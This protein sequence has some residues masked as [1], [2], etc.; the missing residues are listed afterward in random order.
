MRILVSINWLLG[1][2][3]LFVAIFYSFIDQ[4]I[5]KADF[6]VIE[7]TMANIAKAQTG[8]YATGNRYVTFRADE[9][10]AGFGKLNLTVPD[11]KNVLYEAVDADDGVLLIVARVKP[12]AVSQASMKPLVY[13]VTM[14]NGTVVSKKWQK[15]SNVKRGLGLF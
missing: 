12:M 8:E 6:A 10:V 1:T 2:V 5:D 7:S 14:K 15:L 9:W 3:F 13:T 11:D 4:T